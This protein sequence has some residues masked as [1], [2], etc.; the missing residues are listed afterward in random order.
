[1]KI[2]MFENR[3]TAQGSK[4]ML[5][6]DLRRVVDDADDLINALATASVED[7][8]DI[9]ERARQK[10]D[11]ARVKLDDTQQTVSRNVYAAA[12][13]TRIYVKDNPW[14]VAGIAAAVGLL[15]AVLLSYRQTRD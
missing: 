10:L 3:A 4:E 13:A 9:R 2:P 15:T 8:A 6:R 5:K 12:D 7:F 14:R 1:M 11:R